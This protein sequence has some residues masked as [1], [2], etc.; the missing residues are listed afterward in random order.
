MFLH[1]LVCV[2]AKTTTL[3]LDHLSFLRN[4]TFQ[5]QKENCKTYSICNLIRRIL[6]FNNNINGCVL[7][8]RSPLSSSSSSQG[9]AVL[10]KLFGSFGDLPPCPEMSC[11]KW[12]AGLLQPRQQ[13]AAWLQG[14]AP[15]CFPCPNAP[16]LSTVR[17]EWA[18]LDVHNHL[19]CFVFASKHLEC[20]RQTPRSWPYKEIAR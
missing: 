9:K 14:K 5:T 13:P 4:A 2:R 12:L 17:S 8:T 3:F 16:A 11:G 15:C 20:P 18:G 7:L 6:A 19:K 10:S 1:L